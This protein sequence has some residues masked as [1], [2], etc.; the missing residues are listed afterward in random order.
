VDPVCKRTWK[1]SVYSLFLAVLCNIVWNKDCLE[2]TKKPAAGRRQSFININLEQC[3]LK[4][5]QNEVRTPP[6]VRRRRGRQG[7]EK[8]L[9]PPYTWIWHPSAQIASVPQPL[10]NMPI[11]EM[12][13]EETAS[14]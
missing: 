5:W 9:D 14:R 1:E 8:L 10:T 11:F 2:L 4:H 7:D 13:L 3:H 12:W 6:L